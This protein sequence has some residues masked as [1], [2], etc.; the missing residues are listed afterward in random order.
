MRSAPRCLIGV[1]L[2]WL[3][4]PAFLA[5]AEEPA[6]TLKSA[7]EEPS[8]PA[9]APYLVPGLIVDAGDRSS[10][11]EPEEQPSSGYY[12]FLDKTFFHSVAQFFD[13]PRQFRR[14]ADAPKEAE[15][16]NAFDEAPNSTWFENRIFFFPP[17]AEQVRRGSN[18]GEG[19]DPTG[20][21]EV[22]RGKTQGITP[23]F[24]VKDSRGNVY[25]VKFDPPDWPEMA[26]GAEAIS[27]RI[28]YLAGY[29]CPENYLVSLDLDRIVVSPKAQFVDSLGAKR[30]MTRDDVVGLL[31]PLPRQPDGTIRA[32]ASKF[33]A[34]KI[35]GHFRYNDWREDDPN[36]LVPHE[37]RRPLR[38][39]RAISAWTLHND[40][41]SLNTLESYVTD[42]QGKG[43]LMHYM[44]DFGATLGSASLFPNVEYEGHQ[45]IFDG[46]EIASQLVTL[47]IDRRPYEGEPMVITPATGYFE[48]EAFDADDWKPNFPNPAYQNATD[49]DLYWG[50]KIVMS[51]TDGIIDQL[52]HEAHYSQPE[53]RERMARILRE[54]RDKVGR[55]W[56]ARVNPLDRFRIMDGGPLAGGAN[57]AGVNERLEFDDLAIAGGLVEAGTTRYRYRIE[58]P[59]AG[60]GRVTIGKRPRSGRCRSV[61]DRPPPDRRRN[62]VPGRPHRGRR[63]V[64]R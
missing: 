38:G 43:Y 15:D 34:G 7:E 3:L 27:T 9:A 23:G 8:S 33:I 20:N 63:C 22:V 4:P 1:L 44:L 40:C 13:L 36:D 30:P 59:V 45:Y 51:F 60:T 52:V 11:P 54:R 25:V 12:D 10:I 48:S 64:M 41:R 6:T 57:P 19:P 31:A 21:W 46:D 55:E 32:I 50:A 61:W 58:P 24:N 42:A 39:M 35:K 5:R 2:L 62:R 47:G 56:F 26:T 53:D 14:I 37:H 17:T 49:R 28:Y 16:V 18:L 29:H